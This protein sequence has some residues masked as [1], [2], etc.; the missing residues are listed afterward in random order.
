MNSSNNYERF[1]HEIHSESNQ[2]STSTISIERDKNNHE[3][4]DR[5]LKFGT[6]S[7][8]DFIFYLFIIMK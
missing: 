2:Q 6:E 7:V 5:L 1:Y 3:I 8:K 4:F